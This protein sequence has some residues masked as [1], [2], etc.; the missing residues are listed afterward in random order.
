[1]RRLLSWLAVSMAGAL[2][3]PL[4]APADPVLPGR[5]SF[6]ATHT[7]LAD[8]LQRSPFGVPLVVEATLDR[9]TVQGDVYAVLEHPFLGVETALAEP[10]AWC[11]VLTLHFNVKSC[12]VEANDGEGPVT[13]SIET[14]R[15]LYVPPQGRKAMR[16]VLDF[17]RSKPGFLHA[18]LTA[19]KGPL[20]VRNM[21]IELRALALPDGSS[22]L[23]LRY[24][25]DLGFVARL[26]TRTYLATFGR[27]KVGF[28][29]TGYEQSGEPIY[30][31]G[32]LA[33]V[34]RNALRYHLAIVAYLD[35]VQV[36]EN[37]RFEARV[38]RW[39]AHTEHHARQLHEM[40]RDD[41]LEIKRRERRD[42]EAR[43]VVRAS[44]R[45]R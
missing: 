31:R 8:A 19:A 21:R 11:D 40:S 41:Y 6:E 26:A 24:A 16:Y 12:R 28:T 27:R 38:A 3:A 36:P 1:M 33:A 45:R 10:Q 15:K 20:G 5:A 18:S 44:S 2:A 25:Y 14:G 17:S 43:A 35:T 37:E 32:M 30:V 4:D 22:F 7:Q 29:V 9:E 39:F 13:L 42:M 23:Q 34:E